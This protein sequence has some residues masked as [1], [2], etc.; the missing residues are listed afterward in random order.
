MVVDLGVGQVATIFTER[1][2]RFQAQ[3]T[4]FGV[5]RF[6]RRE[7]FEQGLL[8]LLKQQLFAR[9]WLAG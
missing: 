5:N 9:F 2:Q 7:R 3:T 8:L 4:G 1:D 6:E